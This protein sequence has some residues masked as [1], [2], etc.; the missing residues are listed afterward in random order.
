M[1]DKQIIGKYKVQRNKTRE[2]SINHSVTIPEIF[3][4]AYEI[5]FEIAPD[6]VVT[7][8]QNGEVKQQ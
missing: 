2:S 5:V 4:N 3:H 1:F 6:G 7:V 8:R